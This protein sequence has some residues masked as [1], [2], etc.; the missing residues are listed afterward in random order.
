MDDRD[1]GVSQDVADAV[2]H[3][4]AHE[5]DFVFIVTDVPGAASRINHSRQMTFPDAN[6]RRIA[7]VA[8]AAV[9]VWR[10]V[11]SAS[12][13][14]AQ[15]VSAIRSNGQFVAGLEFHLLMRVERR[16]IDETIQMRRDV[17]IRRNLSIKRRSRQPGT[18]AQRVDRDAPEAL[19]IV[20]APR[21]RASQTERTAT[22][23]IRCAAAPHRIL[24]RGRP[25]D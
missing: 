22:R 12:R 19:E 7:G 18:S 24:H 4:L 25:R 2:R 17:T 20:T 15:F 16:T 1:I 13:C 5:M 14:A 6:V 23:Q 11:R 3:L 8:V 9:G 21:G 10:R